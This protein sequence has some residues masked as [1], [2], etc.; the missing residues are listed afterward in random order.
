[1]VILWN[2]ITMCRDF[3]A[4]CSHWKKPV[5]MLQLYRSLFSL[6]FL[7]VRIPIKTGD[8]CYYGNV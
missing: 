8:E 1:M 2:V 7:P 4:R 3:K 6:P 5:V